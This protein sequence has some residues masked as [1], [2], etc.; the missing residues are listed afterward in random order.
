VR[1]TGSASASRMPMGPTLPG[2]R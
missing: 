2:L 1:A